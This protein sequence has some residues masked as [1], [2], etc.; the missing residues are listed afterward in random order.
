MKYIFIIAITAISVSSF[1]QGNSVEVFKTSYAYEAS[2]QYQKA[3]STLE[4][5]DLSSSYSANLRLGWLHYLNANYLKSKS[6]Y[7]T[8]IKLKPSSI[9]AR[10]GL[11][12]PLQVMSN[13]DEVIKVYTA[14]LSIDGNHT[15]S[16]YQLAYIY[17]VRKKYTTAET[18][19]KKILSLYPFDYNSNALL[20]SIYVKLGKIKEAKKHYTIALEYNPS[21][22]DISAILKGL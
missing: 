10:L 19:L 2:G 8:A 18:H 5:I 20:G 15:S 6:F 21:A 22:T 3:I 7:T 16:R 17:F 9:E 11:I 4:K 13:W 1:A 14:I 12:Y